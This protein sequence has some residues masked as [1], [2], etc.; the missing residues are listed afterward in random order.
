MNFEQLVV[1]PFESQFKRGLPAIKSS[2]KPQ[3]VNMIEC[4]TSVVPRQRPKGS[5]SIHHGGNALG[6]GLPPSPSPRN[7]LI[8]PLPTQQPVIDQFQA[9]FPVTSI[10]FNTTKSENDSNNSEPTAM[11][12]TTTSGA[13]ISSLAN[14]SYTDMKA[15]DN[16]TTKH[17]PTELL[18]SLFKSSIYPDPFSDSTIQTTSNLLQLNTEEIDK[19]S[20]FKG[21]LGIKKNVTN[22][23]K[24]ITSP[25]LQFHGT[26]AFISN[27]SISDVCS[28]NNSEGG[29]APGNTS[30]TYNNSNNF[31]KISANC[32]AVT[33]TSN[34]SPSP[35]SSHRRNVSDTSAFNK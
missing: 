19:N 28:V 15:T 20:I 22:S 8:S 4:G 14:N 17:Q 1:P 21:T 34:T 7:T 27:D 12:S 11:L 5:S 6:L 23:T 18:N 10:G 13:V 25:K 31:L 24:I 9:N 35:T 33:N 26:S 3:S 2:V 32:S 30:S 16:S 29:D